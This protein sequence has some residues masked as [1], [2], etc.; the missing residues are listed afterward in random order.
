MK[1][2]L[3]LTTVF[4]LTG[5]LSQLFGQEKQTSVI[6]TTWGVK[7]ESNLSNFYISGVPDAK[8]KMNVGFGVGAYVNVDFN[9]YFGLRGGLMFNN[10][11]SQCEYENNRLGYQSWGVEVPIYAVV[12][13]DMKDKSR[14]YMG[15]GPYTEFG[16][17]AKMKEN[18]QSIDLYKDAAVKESHNGFGVIAGYEF[19][20]GIHISAG[21]KVS[22]TN[23]VDAN[24]NTITLLPA[25]ISLGI[26][27]RFG[28]NR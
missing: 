19:T 4:L 24:S 21:Y 10:K 27:Y 1:K 16:F 17:S 7:A 2:I 11:N 13:W 5:V 26:G 9:N 28:K 12:K 20:S 18:G 3:L 8:S 25:S 14:L 6:K 22:V 15:L 23:L